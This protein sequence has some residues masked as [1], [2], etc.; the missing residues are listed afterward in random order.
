MALLTDTTFVLVSSAILTFFSQLSNVLKL[1]QNVRLLYIQDEK[2]CPFRHVDVDWTVQNAGNPEK[3]RSKTARHSIFME[4]S[5]FST[6]DVEKKIQEEVQ[7]QEISRSY[8]C[9]L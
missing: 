4:S 6:V 3:V 5:A 7:Q 9:V 8:E 1:V 2:F